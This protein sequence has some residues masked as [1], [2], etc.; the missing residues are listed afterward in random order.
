MK[1][2]IENSTNERLI[3]LG[4]II[5]Y[6]YSHVENKK[7]VYLVMN[8]KRIPRPSGGRLTEVLKEEFNIDF[9]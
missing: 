9:Y 8:G 5:E 4:F 7:K 3:K 2:S 1:S 6:S